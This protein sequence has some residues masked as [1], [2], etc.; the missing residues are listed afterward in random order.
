M[1]SFS[2]VGPQGSRGGPQGSRGGRDRGR[3]ER[4]RGGSWANPLSSWLRCSLRRSPCEVAMPLP[5]ATREGHA[6][7]T[8]GLRVQ[9][10]VGAAAPGGSAA[11]KSCV[12]LGRRLSWTL[13]APLA[14]PRSLLPLPHPSHRQG[15]R[16]RSAPAS[17]RSSGPG[18]PAGAGVPAALSSRPSTSSLGL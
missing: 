6:A 10:A 4:R 16:S 2:G 11:R 15:H 3:R 14:E 12:S 5:T 13:R 17:P 8:S 9:V 7:V 18:A 1:G